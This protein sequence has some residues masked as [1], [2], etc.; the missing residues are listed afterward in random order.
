MC[1]YF[2]CPCDFPKFTKD[3]ENTHMHMRNKHTLM[4]DDIRNTRHMYISLVLRVCIFPMP[5]CIFPMP[6][7]ILPLSFVDKGSIH[8]GLRNIHTWTMVL[9]FF[10]FVLY[11]FCG[12]PMYIFPMYFLSH[13]YLFNEKALYV[14]RYFLN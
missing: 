9:F 12:L 11:F 1:V 2:P 6:M 4:D 3:R 5:I 8:M 7:C 13:H 14:P 10:F